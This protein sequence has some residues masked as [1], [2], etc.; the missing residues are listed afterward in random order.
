MS[1]AEFTNSRRKELLKSLLDYDLF[2]GMSAEQVDRARELLALKSYEAGTA[3]WQEEDPGEYLVL[4]LEGDVDITH[5]LTLF[6][7]AS[8]ME[9]GDKALIHLTAD[10][11]PVIGEMSVCAKTPRSASLVAATDIVVGVL[12]QEA[13]EAETREDPRFAAM[14]YHNLSG[15]IARRLIES[16]QNVLKLTTAFSLALHQDL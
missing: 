13:I 10:I 2:T 16:N 7:S 3:V 11:H 4:L 1:A 12:S 6:A 14:L 9:S 8:D 15:I 5:R